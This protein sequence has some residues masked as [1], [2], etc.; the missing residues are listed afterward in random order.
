MGVVRQPKA[1]CNFGFR[2]VVPP[3]DVYRNV[4]AAELG[5]ARDQKMTRVDILPRPVEEIAGDDDERDPL[6]DRQAHQVVE[7]LAGRLTHRLDRRSL[8]ANEPDHRAVEVDIGCVNEF[9]HRKW[10]QLLRRPAC[11]EPGFSARPL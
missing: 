11:P 6:F 7:R 10:P 2:V 5:K 3:H 9:E 4:R 8:V 1:S